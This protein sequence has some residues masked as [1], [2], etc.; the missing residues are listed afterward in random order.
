MTPDRAEPLARGLAPS[1]RR[2]QTN[3]P[4]GTF[5]SPAESANLLSLPVPNTVSNADVQ[6]AID[7]WNLSLTNWHAGIFSPT[8]VPAGGN[9]NFIDFYA[10]T[11][12][13][14]IVGQQYQISQAAGYDSPVRRVL[15][16]PC[17]ACRQTGRQRL[18]PRRAAN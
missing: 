11:N 9:T 10:L 16:R 2:I 6:A 18:R 4:A 15:S 12:L 3:S 5:I 13:L 17:R 1:P 8:N 14:S 7:R